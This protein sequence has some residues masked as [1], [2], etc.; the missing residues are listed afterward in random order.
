[1]WINS[2]LQSV[3]SMWY[4]KDSYNGLVV[5]ESIV[6]YKVLVVCDIN[7]QLLDVGSMCYSKV[8]YTHRC[9]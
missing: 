3:G 8:S 6:S 1:M 9:E 5:C 2:Q 7:S 4:N